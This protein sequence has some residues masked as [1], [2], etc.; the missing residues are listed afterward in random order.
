MNPPQPPSL[1]LPKPPSDLRAVRKG[2]RVT[3]T[4]TVPSVTTDRQTMRNVGPTR[5]CRI[6]SM[7]TTQCGTPVGEIPASRTSGTSGQKVTASFTD[8]LTVSLESDAPQAIATYSVEVLNSSRRGAGLSNPVQVSLL[9]TLPPPADFQARVTAQGVQL[10]W[11]SEVPAISDASIHYVVRVSRSLLGT[12]EST[13][14]GEEPAG[15]EYTLT[16]SAIEWERTYQYRAQTVTVVRQAGKSEVQ[17]DGDD[18]PEV[19]VFADDVFPPAVPSGLQAVSSGPGQQLFV[20]LIWAPDTDADLAGYNVYRG[21]QATAPA[22]LNSEPLKTPAYRDPTVAAGKTY[23]YSV[24]AV[25]Q[26]GNESARS[27]EATETL[28]Q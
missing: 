12:N 14:V 10:S 15:G 13:T 17:V 3:L 26:R 7:Q 2:S 21:E 4:W 24:S 22:K 18:A 28:P 9:R 5:V 27:E 8:T 11:V 1:Y 23:F 16:D 25:D 6:A 20:D 19:K